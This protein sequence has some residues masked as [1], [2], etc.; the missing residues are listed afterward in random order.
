[1]DHGELS[2][3]TISWSVGLA[4]LGISISPARAGTPENTVNLAWRFPPRE[5]GWKLLSMP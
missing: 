5:V 4:P 2:V 1:L 3:P